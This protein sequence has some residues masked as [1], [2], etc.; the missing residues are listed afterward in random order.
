MKT[1]PFLNLQLD[2]AL[3]TGRLWHSAPIMDG[4]WA[5]LAGGDDDYQDLDVFEKI[6]LVTGEVVQLQ[7]LRFPSHGCKPFKTE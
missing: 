6:N 4:D 1:I 5:Y 7:S 2:F 3:P